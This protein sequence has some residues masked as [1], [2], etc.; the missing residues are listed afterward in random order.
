V[1]KLSG[2]IAHSQASLS[3]IISIMNSIKEN[4]GVKWEMKPCKH[5]SFI[6]G[7]CGTI[8]LGNK[9]TPAGIFG[10]INPKVLVNF[11]LN[12]PAAAF[13]LDAQQIFNI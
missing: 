4:F 1:R 13:E 6:P 5:E 12:N 11:G 10:E 9:E 7:R 2:V 3:E 8:F